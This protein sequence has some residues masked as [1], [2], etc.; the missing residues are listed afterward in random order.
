VVLFPAGPEWS[1]AGLAEGGN[2]NATQAA[3][4]AVRVRFTGFVR[5]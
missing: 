1:L 3:L 5:A 4:P 2:V